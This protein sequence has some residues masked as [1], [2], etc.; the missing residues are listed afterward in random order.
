MPVPDN[1]QTVY[2]LLPKIE[3]SD[4]VLVDQALSNF[5]IEL[6]ESHDLIV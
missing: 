3:L 6:I 4:R 5:L 1:A 2:S